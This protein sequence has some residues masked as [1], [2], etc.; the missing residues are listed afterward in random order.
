MMPPPFHRCD[1]RRLSRPIHWPGMRAGAQGR[2]IAL[3]AAL[4]ALCLGPA[5]VVSAQAAGA[6]LLSEVGIDQKLNAQL[7]LDLAFRNERGKSVRLRDC[8]GDKPVIL[9]LIYYRCP[10]LC[11]RTMDGLI[12]TLRTM[13][14]AVGDDFTVLSVSFDPH[15]GPRQAASAKRAALERYGRRGAA[16]GWHFLTGD[17][18]AIRSLTDTVGFRYAYDPK[19]DQY[20]HAAGLVVLTP[21]GKVSRY[22][23]GIE[24]AARDLRFSL[25]EA[26]ALK[27]GSVADQVLLLCYQYNPQTGKYGL[28]I[29]AVIRVCGLATV[30]SMAT[31]ILWMLRRERRLNR[32]NQT[33]S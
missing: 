24:F 16:R 27:I 18:A 9:N 26:S 23:G 20:A 3:A 13:S 21:E 15:E 32:L 4:G 25:V 19:L 2:F 12:R 11:S 14:L 5:T 28:V 31:A 30:A 6:N 22:L 17:E 33:S 29:Q 8:L 7:P 1:A 10:M